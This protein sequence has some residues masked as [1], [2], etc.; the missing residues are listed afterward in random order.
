MRS[1]SIAITVHPRVRGGDT[2]QL[3]DIGGDTGSSPRARGRRHRNDGRAETVRFIPACAGETA[4]ARSR[5]R[6]PTVHPRV[7][8]GDTLFDR[9]RERA[10][11]SSPRARGRHDALQRSAARR[12]FI[13]ACAGETPSPI[14][15][16]CR[17]RVHPRVR[18]GDDIPH[19]AGCAVVGSSPRARGRP[20]RARRARR[21]RRFIP[22]CAGETAAVVAKSS[23]SGV[24]PRVRGGDDR[25][26]VS[27]PALLGSS[28]RARGRLLI[29]TASDHMSQAAGVRYLAEP[30]SPCAPVSSS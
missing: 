3:T 26:H 16:V 8:G 30:S 18:G 23:Q 5:C 9:L 25:A 15:S 12:G 4:P 29:Y 11:G 21:R 13:P 24:H 17:R 10:S 28:P 22:A 1:T 14:S 20:A 7:R 2:T 6:S 19:E 27:G